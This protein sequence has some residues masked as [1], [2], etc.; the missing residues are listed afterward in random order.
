LRELEKYKRIGQIADERLSRARER[1]S[2]FVAQQTTKIRNTLDVKMEVA[3]QKRT[4][5]INVII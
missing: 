3:V 4:Q 5:L 1:R 2:N